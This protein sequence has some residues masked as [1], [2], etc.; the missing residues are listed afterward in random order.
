MTRIIDQ[1]TGISIAVACVFGSGLFLAG[2]YM[3]KVDALDRMNIPQRLAYIQADL[4]AIK[5]R[6][7]IPT[8]P[9]AVF[10]QTLSAPMAIKPPL[11]RPPAVPQQ[12]AILPAS[13]SE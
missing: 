9:Q 13:R 7:G 12:T 8:N 3:G 4:G 11:P 6:L 10:D 5:L 2:N 1:R